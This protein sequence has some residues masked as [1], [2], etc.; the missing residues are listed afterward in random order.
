MKNIIFYAHSEYV[1]NVSD[2]PAP[3]IKQLPSWYK[4]WPDTLAIK[5][6]DD[7]YSKSLLTGKS[8][9][10]FFDALSSGYYLTLFDD[11]LVT[12]NDLGAPYIRW[13]G[14]HVVC[15]TRPRFDPHIPIPAGCDSTPFTWKLTF[16][17]KLPKGY[18]A[19]I[20][21][22][23]NRHELPFVTGSGIMDGD[24]F[25][26]T[27]NIPFWIKKGFEGYIP[28]GTP[29][30]QVIPIKRESWKSSVAEETCESG[31]SF[32]RVEKLI[33]TKKRGAYKK[34]FW[35]KKDYT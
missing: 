12:T 29:Y 10:P 28:A 14:K 20:T 21:H 30:A 13:N 8:C 33:N 32:W 17:P 15:D 31:K 35:Q 34:Y 19:L 18:S 7:E 9:A 6:V 11:L 16:A 1:K 4:E 23:L 27:G 2:A 25:Y 24:M 22:P 5:G 3:A 26:S